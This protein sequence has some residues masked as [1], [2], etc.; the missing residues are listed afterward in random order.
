MILL[1]KFYNTFITINSHVN[2]VCK[3]FYHIDHNWFLLKLCRSSAI[4]ILRVNF[5]SHWSQ[6]ISVTQDFFCY[7]SYLQYH[8]F[9]IWIW[10]CLVWYHM[11]IEYLLF[12][13]LIFAFCADKSLQIIIIWNIAIRSDM[14]SKSI[15]FKIRAILFP[16]CSSGR[17]S[18]SKVSTAFWMPM[19]SIYMLCHRYYHKLNNWSIAH[20]SL[21]ILSLEVIV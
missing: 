3:F 1:C 4:E 8:F 17:S 20:P 18:A 21:Q 5:N 2:L 16:T 13:A 7:F 12:N 15:S 14:L 6:L 10:F 19:N 9:A 11:F